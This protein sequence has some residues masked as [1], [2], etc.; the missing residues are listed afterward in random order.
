MS[1]V[2]PSGVWPYST[3][4]S[5]PA[6]EPTAMA[7]LALDLPADPLIRLQATDGSFSAVYPDGVACW[8][9]SWVTSL[10]LLAL[11]RRAPESPAISKAVDWLAESRGRESHWLWRWKFKA[12]DT[13]VRFDPDKY[14]WTWAPGTASWVIPTALAVLGLRIA[15]PARS[16][17]VLRERI[18]L[19]CAMLLDRACKGGGWNAG[20]AVAFGVEFAPHIDATAIAL[21][22]L[23]GRGVEVPE[24]FIGESR[25]CR[26]VASTAWAIL[27]LN[28]YG[29]GGRNHRE[30]LCDLLRERDAWNDN[31]SLAL[32]VLA[33]EPRHGGNV[34]K[35]TE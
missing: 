24:W 31:A 13:R 2:L 33:L 29:D 26:G 19:G 34:F 17:P 21:L 30:R 1:R 14:G 3:R 35:V 15:G 4:C 22:A 32:A 9:G 28:A 12:V 11:L 25:E 10:A 18:D 27:A 16:S 5:Q 6:T 8:P 20:N 7:T 23:Q